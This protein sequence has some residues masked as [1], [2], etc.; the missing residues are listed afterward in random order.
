MYKVGISKYEKIMFAVYVCGFFLFAN[1][2]N[3]DNTTIPCP[4]ECGN[5]CKYNRQGEII[6]AKCKDAVIQQ[7][8]NSLE[9]LHVYD[10]VDRMKMPLGKFLGFILMGKENLTSL[11]IENYHLTSLEAN[12]FEN[13]PNLERLDISRNSI[14]QISEDSFSGLKNLTYLNL[15]ENLLQSL[16]DNLFRQ[17]PS[18]TELYISRNKLVSIGDKDFGGLTNIGKIVLQANQIS[19]ISTLAFTML[20]T[21]EDINLQENRLTAVGA[22]IFKNIVTL[23]YINL[24]QNDISTIDPVSM[25]GT[26]NLLML[27][28]AENKITMFPTALLQTISNPDLIVNIARNYIT[29]LTVDAFDNV[30]LKGLSLTTNNISQIHPDALSN[31][32]I[33]MLDLRENALHYIPEGFVENIPETTGIILK[34]NPWVCDCDIESVVKLIEITD[35]ELL[36]DSPMNYSGLKISNV[37]DEL[38]ESCKWQV[39]DGLEKGDNPVRVGVIVGSVAGSMALIAGVTAAV[40]KCCVLSRKVAPK[41]EDQ[42]DCEGQNADSDKVSSKNIT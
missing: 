31:S 22:G 19:T 20:T 14:Q 4:I 29:E 16:G 12:C 35:E 42:D 41:N 25:E 38:R 18:L 1:V 32:F 33:Q 11:K 17:L 7:L 28:L 5:S 39:N 13:A 24:Q 30:I 23:K 36:C 10:I 6:S 2:C 15:N 37:T 21:I 8:P 26:S 40:L 3:A 9:T 27:K 34:D